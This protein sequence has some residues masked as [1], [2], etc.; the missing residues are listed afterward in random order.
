MRS[1][2]TVSVVMVVTSDW[3]SRWTAWRRWRGLMTRVTIQATRGMP[4][5]TMRP[6]RTETDTMST[7]TTAKDTAEPISGGRRSKKLPMYW[8][9][10]ATIEATSPVEAW[11]GRPAP[12]ME[13]WR[14]T[15]RVTSKL[16]RI[17]AYIPT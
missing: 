16:V 5:S 1:P 11:R 8:A 10:E 6:R 3:A 4:M 15:S 2:A 14:P 9:S 13:T 7:A 17:Q 12:V